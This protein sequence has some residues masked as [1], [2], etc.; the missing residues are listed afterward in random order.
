MGKFRISILFFIFASC[1]AYFSIQAQDRSSDT[2]ALKEGS[3]ALQFGI[4]SN[5]TLTSFQ[6]ATFAAKYQISN[7]NAIRG[8]VTIN[9]NTNNGDGSNSDIVDDTSIGAASTSNSA[10]ST[11]ITFVIQYLWY[12]NP[13]AQV[14]FYIGIG[15]SFSYSYAYNSSGYN[16]LF[17]VNGHGY[18]SQ[19]A[20]SSN[21]TQ[22]SIGAEG[23][24]GVEWFACSWLSIHAEYN[25]GVQYQWGSTSA[26]SGY[27]ST[28][29]ANAPSHNNTNSN[30]NGWAL[31]SSGVSF[32][33][34]I[35]L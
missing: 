1:I 35:Y 18:W 9:G 32:G 21:S 13:N 10:K 5:F 22:R 16:N 30:N 8:G 20:S 34:N 31:N 25:E 11:S 6:G 26:S 12:M 33:L 4:A 28:Y 19:Q 3:W 27:S 24:A 17:F 14:H 23:I 7:T 2:T 29:P 15:P